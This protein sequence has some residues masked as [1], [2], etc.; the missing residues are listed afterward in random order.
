LLLLVDHTS[1]PVPYKLSPPNEPSNPDSFILP[2][3]VGTP[4]N[5]THTNPTLHTT[6]FTAEQLA[7][8]LWAL[9]NLNY[10]PGTPLLEAAGNALLT[11]LALCAPKQAAQVWR[12]RVCGYMGF[13]G[14]YTA[15]L[16]VAGKATG[17][18]K[19][20]VLMCT[21]R[22]CPGTDQFEVHCDGHARHAHDVHNTS[23]LK[24]R[25]CHVPV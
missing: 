11:N 16:F 9:A 21:A 22:T 6:G 15:V 13:V 5:P 19:S 25:R 3:F 1:N 23:M 8:M 10:I 12:E 18:I 24:H 17:Q 2:T 20:F 7:N 14:R 4:T